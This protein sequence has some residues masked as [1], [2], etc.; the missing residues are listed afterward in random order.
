MVWVALYATCF[1]A[2]SSWC[3]VLNGRESLPQSPSTVP[4]PYLSLCWSWV[5]A[6]VSVCSLSAAD[7]RAISRSVAPGRDSTSYN[8]SIVSFIYRTTLLLPFYR[9]L[10]ASI[11]V[12][13]AS[14]TLLAASSNLCLFSGLSS[15]SRS[16]SSTRICE[17]RI[18]WSER[19]DQRSTPHPDQ[20][21]SKN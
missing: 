6:L 13:V 12:E 11:I 19:R 15:A 18:T 16:N 8:Q 9:T 5:T 21:C 10:V 3:I 4:L 7:R 14:A 2:C 20:S 17:W 1:A